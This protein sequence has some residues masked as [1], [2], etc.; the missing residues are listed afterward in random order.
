MPRCFT[1]ETEY[2]VALSTFPEVCQILCKT[3]KSS[4][5]LDACVIV[6]RVGEE[7]NPQGFNKIIQLVHSESH[8]NF[9]IRSLTQRIQNGLGVSLDRAKWFIRTATED[10]KVNLSFAS[11][12]ECTQLRNIMRPFLT[13][14][15][16]GD[17]SP[18]KLYQQTLLNITKPAQVPLS[19]ELDYRRIPE[20]IQ[21]NL[22]QISFRNDSLNLQTLKKI[23]D[24]KCVDRLDLSIRPSTEQWL[25][26]VDDAWCELISQNSSG[27]INSLDISGSQIGRKGMESLSKMENLRNLNLGSTKITDSDLEYFSTGF[28]NVQYL[29]LNSCT[30]LTGD[31]LKYLNIKTLKYLDTCNTYIPDE[32][33]SKLGQSSPDLI[34]KYQEKKVEEKAEL[35]DMVLRAFNSVKDRLPNDRSFD[36]SVLEQMFL[37]E[38]FGMTLGNPNM[39]AQ[40]RARQML[41]EEEEEE[42]WDD[43]QI[44]D[45]NID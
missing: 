25:P 8:S 14:I 35:E 3:K 44:D 39:V 32:S 19:E 24:T 11:F 28:S 45:E 23:L 29:I 37:S 31:C 41:Q 34:V 2:S 30:N 18:L 4:I 13:I 38:V 15:T 5:P 7:V 12:E 40:M 22:L 43:D 16:E 9:P 6:N 1:L 21:A 33:V 36:S 27:R 10:G 17:G 20:E 42:G 26:I